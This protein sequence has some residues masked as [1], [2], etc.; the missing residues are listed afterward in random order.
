MSHGLAK[1]LLTEE[2]LL[3][4]A[5]APLQNSKPTPIPYLILT[6]E[7]RT[8]TSGNSN[9]AMENHMFKR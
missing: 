6:V 7:I 3:V 1:Q 4:G 9:I 8:V 5:H 2:G